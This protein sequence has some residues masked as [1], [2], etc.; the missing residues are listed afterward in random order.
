MAQAIRNAIR[1]NQL[2][3]IIRYWHPYFYRAS[4]RFARITP[5]RR[6]IP[7]SINSWTEE[8]LVW[9]L[10]GL[11]LQG[12]SAWAQGFPGSEIPQ[13]RIDRLRNLLGQGLYMREIGTIWQIGVLTEKPCTFLLKN[14]SL[15]AFSHFNTKERDWRG[16]DVELHIPLRA[17]CL[18]QQDSDWLWLE[19]QENP[20]QAKMCTVSKLECQ[21]QR[22]K[23]RTRP[24][25]KENH[26]GNFSGL[27]AK[28]SRSVVDTKSLWKPGKPYLPPKSFLCGP[29]FFSKAKFCT[30]AGR[31]L[32]SL[33]QN[34]PHCVKILE[35][36]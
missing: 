27:K 19:I 32:L 17:W 14:G 5:L 3:R 25:P 10:L 6:G 7:Q 33:S 36:S 20:F 24:P 4:G 35:T 15:S 21:F 30:G 11:S 22:R 29:H 2:A 12:W 31:C 28:L 8:F 23:K 34:L 18:H 26:L 1:A 16:V 13:L 9:G